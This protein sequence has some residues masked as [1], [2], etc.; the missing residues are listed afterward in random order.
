MVKEKKTNG[1][2]QNIHKELKIEH[3]EPH[4]KPGMLQE[5][6]QFLIH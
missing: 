2:L 6:E 5:G 4:W 1:D 3:H